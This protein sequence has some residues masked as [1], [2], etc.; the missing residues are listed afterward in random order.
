MLFFLI[1]AAPAGAAPPVTA[2]TPITPITPITPCAM[3][4]LPSPPA[5]QRVSPHVWRVAA[6]AGDPSASN[7]GATTQL[8]VVRDGTRT[9]L[10]GS[11]PTPRYGEALACVIEHTLGRRVTDVVNARAAPELAMGNIA[12]NHARLHALPDVI[13]TMQRRCEACRARLQARIGDAGAG[14][15]PE[16]VRTPALPVGETADKPADTAPHTSDTGR[17]GPFDWLAVSRR[18]GERVLVLRHR[19]DRIVFAPGLVWPGDTPD[20]RETDSASLLQSLRRL[21]AMAAGARLLGEQGGVATTD[22]VDSHMAYLQALREALQPRVRAGD[23]PAARGD[24]VDLPAYARTPS[25]ASRH[26]LNVQRVY[27]ELETE[28]LR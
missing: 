16:S 5:L 26:P 1:A 10:L 9:W 17:L 4:D 8:A 23:E 2:V 27:R 13:A 12:F 24:G 25:H 22:A 19:A 15:V 14:L 28:L 18:P 20:L 11:G 6:A 3:D 7:G 21:R